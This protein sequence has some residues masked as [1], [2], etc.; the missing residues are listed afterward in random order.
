MKTLFAIIYNL[1][2]CLFVGTLMSVLGVPPV[3][4]YVVAMTLFCVGLIPRAPMTGVL[5]DEVLITIFSSD[6]Q[7]NISP[8]NSFYKQSRVDDGVAITATSVQIPQAGQ[9]A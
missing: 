1:F 6:I 9:R 3:A 4:A 7:S 5:R 2:V 8:D